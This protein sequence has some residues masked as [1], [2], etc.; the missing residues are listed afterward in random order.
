MIKKLPDF[1]STEASIYHVERLYTKVNELVKTINA[2]VVDVDE[3]KCVDGS[4][5]M[6]Q[7]PR[8]HEAVESANKKLDNKLDIAIDA[9]TQIYEVSTVSAWKT[10]EE[11]LNKIKELQ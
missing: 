4:K 1:D 5:N 9:L 6:V 7:D 2:I 10:A 11:A 8:I 3:T